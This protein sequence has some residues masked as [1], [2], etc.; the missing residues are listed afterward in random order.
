F[1]N[2]DS[3]GAIAL[4]EAARIPFAPIAEPADLFDDP[5]LEATGGLL[6]TT[7]PNGTKTKL[8]RLPFQIAGHDLGIR[9]DPPAMGA[10][11]DALLAEL[12]YDDTAIDALRQSGVIVTPTD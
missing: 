3:A 2:L 8:P 6:P 7:M 11:T 9:S 10:D 1:R 12:G 5:H 4:C